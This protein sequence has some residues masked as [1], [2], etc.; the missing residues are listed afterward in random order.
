MKKVLLLISP[1]FFLVACSSM[2]V[3]EKETKRTE[4]D[5]MAATTIASLMKKDAALQQQI[6]DSAGYAVANM[7]VTKVPV[8]GAGGGEGV[9][10]NKK[11]KIRK[12]FTVS[13]FDIGEFSFIIRISCLRR[14]AWIFL[15]N[16]FL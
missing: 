13:R 10:V 2:S 4:L 7:K 3:A 11:T 9:F 16:D 14:F 6:D 12:Y 15:F 5:E 1:I 8:V